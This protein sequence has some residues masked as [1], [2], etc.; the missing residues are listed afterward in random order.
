MKKTFN[1][2][3]GSNL[4]KLVIIYA[5]YSTDMQNPQSCEDQVRV[6]KQQLTKL[7][8]AHDDAQVI[9]DEGISGTR[10]NRPGYMKLLQL[11]EQ[12]RVSI[13]AVDELS[14]LTRLHDAMQ[15]IQ[16][17][18]YQQGRFLSFGENIDSSVNG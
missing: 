4:Q 9:L 11:I 7:G 14:R 10:A 12:K 15:V 17:I 1:G 5:R 16:N 3:P 6:V 18:N 8:I 13:L 2:I